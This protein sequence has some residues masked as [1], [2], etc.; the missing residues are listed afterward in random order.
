MT[1]RH[2][3]LGPHLDLLMGGTTYS[4]GALAQAVDPLL[5]HC[6]KPYLSHICNEERKDPSHKGRVWQERGCGPINFPLLCNELE[7]QQFKTAVRDHLI[8]LQVTG[9]GGLLQAL[10]LGTD[11]TEIKGPGS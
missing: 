9:I 10:C 6:L 4:P 8:V 5:R 3:I 2:L 11:E 7:I 1:H